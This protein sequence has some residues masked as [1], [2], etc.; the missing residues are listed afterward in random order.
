MK[1]Y[2]K[3]AAKVLTLYNIG[4]GKDYINC[5][6]SQYS[7]CNSQFVCL[8]QFFFVPLHRIFNSTLRSVK[9][10]KSERVY[11]SH[12]R[13]LHFIEA[14]DSLIKKSHSSKV[15]LDKI[16]R[17]AASSAA[18]QF[19][20]APKQALEMYSRYVRTGEIPVSQEVTRRMYLC[21]FE[22]YKAALEQNGNTEFK[23]SIMQ[24]V[25]ESPAPSFFISPKMA[26]YYYYVSMRYK[27]SL[28]RNK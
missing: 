5:G 7:V 23:Y 15:K 27:R 28:S 3:I 18:P 16:C 22:K 11:N 12:L 24:E 2:F 21:L 10:R 9:K 25:I 8:C 19:Y 4:C 6:I 26:A 20:I 1:H 14:V 13:H 17:I